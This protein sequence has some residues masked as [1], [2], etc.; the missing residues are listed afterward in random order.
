MNTL[1]NRL[2]LWSLLMTLLLAP[3]ATL[4]LVNSVVLAQTLGEC[5]TGFDGEPGQQCTGKEYCVAGDA[6]DVGTPITNG[7]S[8]GV[9]WKSTWIAANDRVQTGTCTLQVG[10]AC[11]QCSGELFCAKGLMY[12]LTTCNSSCGQTGYIYVDDIR[13][14]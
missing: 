3:A 1:N 11:S 4:H 6:C 8:A 9:D 12:S 2:S 13:C 7:C 14:I 5:E 10:Q